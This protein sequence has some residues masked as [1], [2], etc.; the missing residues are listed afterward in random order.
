VAR[1][2]PTSNEGRCSADEEE[3]GAEVEAEGT[4]EEEKTEE[5]AIDGAEKDG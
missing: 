1:E 3:V 5:E 4:E 2:R